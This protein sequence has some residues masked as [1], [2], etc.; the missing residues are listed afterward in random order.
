MSS[1]HTLLCLAGF[2]VAAPALAGVTCCDV[3]GKRTCGDPAPMQCLNKAKTVFVKGAAKEIEA[4]LT[5]EQ[6]AAREA[7]EE[8]GLP[9]RFEVGD[10]TR[11]DPD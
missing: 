9:A 3:D 8:E 2:L 5:P 11:L 4:P 6:K 7:A 10:L 1:K